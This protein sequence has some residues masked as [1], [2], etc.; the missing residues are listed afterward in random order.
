ME[1]LSDQLE[2]LGAEQATAIASARRRRE[3]GEGCANTLADLGRRIAEMEA[4]KGEVSRQVERAE[5]AASL[6]QRLEDSR[7]AAAG[8]EDDLDDR[9]ARAADAA[10]EAERAKDALPHL[11]FLVRHRAD[12]RRAVKEEADACKA[13]SNAGAEVRRF[14]AEEAEAKDAAVA[15]EA[16]KVRAKQAADVAAHKLSEA[17]IRLE[18]FGAV[19]LLG[20]PSVGRRSTK[21]TPPESERGSSGCARDAEAKRK[22]LQNELD[23]AEAAVEATRETLKQCQAQRQKAESISDASGRTR[24]QAK[25]RSDTARIQFDQAIAELAGEYASWVAPIEADGFPT[26]MDMDEIR[27]LKAALPGLIQGRDRL[28]IL[29]EERDR[30]ASDIATLEQAVLA[31]GAPEDVSAARE[32][33]TRLQRSLAELRADSKN[34]ADA[35]A[36]PR[37]RNA[38]T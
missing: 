22:D 18:R 8:L 19:A 26:T 35:R 21:N 10:D 4:R 14:L 31:V 36:R 38:S 6:C 12:F 13:E 30:T 5:K 37:Q 1:D 32:E 24:V 7:K 15:A 2:K 9:Y 29:V 23:H 33:V 25:E 20:A 27:P 11:E 17:N 34:A 3:N 28:R 16:G